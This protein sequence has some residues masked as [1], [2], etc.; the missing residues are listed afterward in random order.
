M[1]KIAFDL[2]PLQAGFKA[3]KA[4]GI[5]VYTRNI[6]ARRH[7]APPGV[8]LTPFHDPRYESVES[9]SHGSVPLELGVLAR[10]FCPYLKEFINQRL[11]MRRSLERFAQKSKADILY[12][13]TH[14]DV[15]SGLRIPYAVTAHDMIQSALKDRFYGSLKSRLAVS[16]QMD[17][18]KGAAVIFAVS[19]HTKKDVVKHAGTDPAKIIVASNGVDTVFRP[20]GGHLPDGLI[21]DGRFVLN[22]GGIDWRKNTPLLL[23]SFAELRRKHPEW[24]LVVTGEIKNDPLY[25]AFRRFVGESGLE[26]SV[27]EVGYVTSETLSALY[28]RADIFFYPSLYEGFGLPVLEAMACGTPVISTD[29]ASIPE[30]VGTAGVLLDPDKPQDFADALI[31]LAESDDERKSLSE[32]G[33]K[34]ARM[35]TWDACAEKV[36]RGLANL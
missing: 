21:P 9:A 10:L 12:F 11:F 15:P 35:F 33:L 24:R 30:V 8:E 23:R 17:V 22:V 29:R 20:G 2:R 6:I 27:V 4:R 36:Y 19:E 32:A 13:P 18:L 25:P 31:R 28:N 16:R 1:K 14:L 3:H 5:G 26:K 34:R 7:L